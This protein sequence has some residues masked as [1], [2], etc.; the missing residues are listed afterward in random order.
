MD[1]L[2]EYGLFLAETATVVVA[3]VIV[4]ATVAANTGRGR[5]P[6][7]GHLE[8][9]CLNDQLD[10]QRDILEAAVLGKKASRRQHK[11]RMRERKKVHGTLRR[12]YVLNF[13][14]D[15]QASATDRLRHEVTSVLSV[16][17]EEDEVV[18][19]LESAGGVVHGYGLAASQLQRIK[20]QGISL[21]VAVDKVAASG[22]YLVACLA[23]KLISSPFAVLGSIGVMAEVPNVHRLLKKHDVDVELL[24]A[25]EFKRT[26][27]VFGENTEKG[28]EKFIEELEDVHKLFKEHVARHRPVVDIDAVSTGESWYGPRALDRKLSDELATSDAYL[29]KCCDDAEV[30]EVRWAIRRSPIERLAQRFGALLGQR[31]LADY[32][33]SDLWRGFWRV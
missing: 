18:L 33:N 26:L 32:V 6:D 21:T 13:E 16:A 27:T 25:G 2:A 22:G 12:V 11:A 7:E 28:R 4:V 1:L 19:R 9:R 20:E 10:H 17:R 8:V 31:R 14:G 3:I 29:A 5:Q 23:D 30:Y 24:T 15:L